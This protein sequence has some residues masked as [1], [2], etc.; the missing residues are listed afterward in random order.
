MGWRNWKLPG[1]LDH[2][3]DVRDLGKQGPMITLFEGQSLSTGP[4]EAL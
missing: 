2:V 4:H 3:D 1:L